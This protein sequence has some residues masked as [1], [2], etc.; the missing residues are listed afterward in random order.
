MQQDM[1]LWT[2]SSNGYTLP[3]PTLSGGWKSQMNQYFQDLVATCNS[4]ATKGGCAATYLNTATSGSKAGT[5]PYTIASN[6]IA[7]NIITLQ[8]NP[9]F[10]GGPYQFSG[11]QKI[12]PKIGTVVFKYVPDQTTREIDLQNAAKSGQALAIDL[13]ATNLYDIADRGQWLQHNTLTSTIS[14]ISVYGPY[15]FLG[16]TFDP[17]NTNV[18]SPL[19][20][21][22]YKFQPFADQ[23]IRLAFADA[24]NMTSEWLSSDNKV[25]QVA[26]NVIP[27]GLPPDGSFNASTK[28]AYSFSPLNAQ[29]LLLDAMQHPLTSFTF[30]NG[31][32]APSGL[33]D[34]TFG[35][36]TL[37]N[38]KCANP[39]GQTVT[40]TFGTGDTVDEAI[41]NDLAGTINN[42]STT[43]NMGLT[44]SVQ[45]LPTGQMLTEA[46]SI[47]T[48]LYMYALGWILDY[49]WVT[50]FTGNMLAYPGT[51]PGSDG[52]NIKSINDL[53]TQSQKDSAAGNLP[54]L[55][56]DSNKM[57]IIANKMVMYLWTYDNVN[58]ITMTS[59]VQ[60][61]YFNPSLSTAA[62]A[63]VGPE[64]FATLY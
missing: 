40:L 26:P 55:I 56:A 15:P 35:C 57:N 4:G 20:G 14:G 45:P 34:N 64:Y 58:Y 16:V 9:S 52:W 44:V 6:D 12:T 37:S 21:Q 43:Y 32:K 48:H 7:K 30:V 11:G 51:Y 13:T 63:G 31:T 46:F 54:G 8:A 47:P 2:Q 61:F 59:N 18:T 3:F 29:N 24:V 60:G 10:W 39:V 28:P 19:T 49:P 25:G 5:G 50:D 41:M 53:F 33:F 42:I 62:A 38:G 1:A 17:F 27:P 22:Y 23:R 36:T